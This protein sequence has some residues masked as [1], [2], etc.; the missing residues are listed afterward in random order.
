MAKILGP[1]QTATHLVPAFHTFLRDIDEVKTGV[2]SHFA[3]FLSYLPPAS[4][5]DFLEICWEL[6]SESDQNWRL[7]KLLAQYGHLIIFQTYFSTF[8]LTIFLKFV[9]GK[10]VNCVNPSH[11]T[12]SSVSLSPCCAIAWRLFVKRCCRLSDRCS[13][14]C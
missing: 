6:Q 13:A 1:A 7:R 5:S 11:L 4:R 8:E 14:T 10:S 2:V 9:T 3:A 12:S